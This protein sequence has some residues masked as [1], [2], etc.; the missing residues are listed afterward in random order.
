M[1]SVDDTGS[2]TGLC[3]SLSLAF[4]HWLLTLLLG[5]TTSLGTLAT[6]DLYHIVSIGVMI[7]TVLHQVATYVTTSFDNP[8]LG[9][10]ISISDTQL[11]PTVGTNQDIIFLRTAR[12]PFLRGRRG[13]R[14]R[15]SK[16]LMV[17]SATITTTQTKIEADDFEILRPNADMHVRREERRW[18]RRRANAA[19]MRLSVVMVVVMMMV[20]VVLG[21]DRPSEI[22]ETLHMPAQAGGGVVLGLAVEDGECVVWQPVV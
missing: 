14:H 11:I 22:V 10:Q 6:I 15:S 12:K 2:E 16:R 4:A 21:G 20:M 13:R 18:R 5:A 7:P 9:L 19:M 3:A 8:D 17:P 1:A